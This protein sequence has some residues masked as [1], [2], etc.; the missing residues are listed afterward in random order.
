MG[1]TL[2]TEVILNSSI[3]DEF[4]LIH[5]DTSDHREIDTLGALDFLNVYLAVKF[6]VF[7]ILKILRHWPDLVY[8]PI[9]QTTIGYI[10]D[11]VFILI[12]KIL[13]RKTI[14]HLRG[15]NFRNWLENASP[16]TRKYVTR[17][18]RL[19]DGQIVLG[20]C[21]RTLFSG[22]LPQAKIHVVPNGKDIVYPDIHKPEK[23]VRLLFLANIMRTKGVLDVLHAA[24]MIYSATPEVEFIFC[25]A[26]ENEALREEIEA[27]M[28]SNSDLP[29]RW[30]GPVTGLEKLEAIKNSDIFLFPT[31]YPPEGHPWVIIEAMA[32]Q[33]PVIA[34]DQGAITESVID[35]ENGF[36]VQKQNPEM[37]AEKAI[38]LIRNRDLRTRMGMASRKLYEQNFT[39]RQMTQR[40]S[41]AFL[42]T[43]D[44]V[45]SNGPGTPVSG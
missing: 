44:S 35:G 1:P 14:C 36:I 29:V 27:F 2:A 19:V 6:Y 37:L 26:W 3:K 39:E 15:G 4:E 34:T 9:S 40:L 38:L 22:I 28:R 8:I 31:Y 13:R 30:V 23:P 12:A 16:L 11:S 10:K 33:L 32:A 18:H 7:M 42:K 25:G 21:L 17:V 20:E 24:P 43:L 41:E 45:E 5:L